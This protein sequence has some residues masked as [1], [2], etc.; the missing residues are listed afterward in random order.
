MFG[1][2]AGGLYKAPLGIIP[3][4]VGSILGCTTITALNIITNKL[5]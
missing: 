2:I 1:T 5:N 4:G 3:L